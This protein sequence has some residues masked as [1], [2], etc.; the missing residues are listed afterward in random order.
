MKGSIRWWIFGIII[1]ILV[2]VIALYFAQGWPNL[3]ELFMNQ[4][5]VILMKYSTCS[6]AYCANGADSD[7]VKKVGCLKKEAGKC[8]LTCEDVEEKIFSKIVEK[9]P[10]FTFTSNSNKHYCGKDFALEFEFT[11]AWGGTVPL[12]SGQMDSF[13]A[14]QPQWV[15]KPVKIPFTDIEID[16]YQRYAPIPAFLKLT[17]ADMQYTGSF[18]GIEIPKNCIM[19]SKSVPDSAT[20]ANTI[21]FVVTF[22]PG[23]GQA[24]SA[25]SVIKNIKTDISKI[26]ELK[27]EISIL[28][29]ELSERSLAGAAST[30]I[31]GDAELNDPHLSNG[32]LTKGGCFT[33][34]V[35]DLT[36]DK[37]ASRI[38]VLYS[39]ILQYYNTEKGRKVKV[40]PSAIYVDESFIKSSECRLEN[41]EA[42]AFKNMDDTEKNK[43]INKKKEEYK[44][45]HKND[46]KYN[47]YDKDGNLI[48]LQ[49]VKVEKTEGGNDV[50][51]IGSVEN[52]GA[53][54]ALLEEDAEKHARSELGIGKPIFGVDV[55]G[56]SVLSW[57]S[58]F[59]IGNMVSECN[60]RAID[61]GKKIQYKVWSNPTYPGIGTVVNIEK[62]GESVTEPIKEFFGIQDDSSSGI[63]N[64]V[65]SDISKNLG[66]KSAGI[67]P[68]VLDYSKK[69]QNLK[70]VRDD[71][72][73]GSDSIS[74]AEEIVKRSK[75]ELI[76]YVYNSG[77]DDKAKDKIK[78][79]IESM[80]SSIESSTF[81]KDIKK[82]IED[83]LRE[84]GVEKDKEESTTTYDWH[85]NFGS[86]AYV[87]L[88]R[89][90][91]SVSGIIDQDQQKSST[92]Q[93]SIT[94]EGDKS[95]YNKNDIATFSGTLR[96]GPLLLANEEVKLVLYFLPGI[97]SPIPL[98]TQSVLTDGSGKFTW[99]TQLGGDFNANYQIIAEYNGVKSEPFKFTV[100]K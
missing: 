82:Y 17:T 27:N 77:I 43:R 58:Y 1:A 85:E 37:E 98:S 22:I 35:Y 90:L 74:V 13:L 9:N 100:G 80:E 5:Q 56:I 84:F 2:I 66:I 60:F 21:S 96:D 31:L 68:L 12:K 95:S 8:V 24:K 14:K 42:A 36:D 52:V 19:L 76:G 40:Y 64:A 7:Q 29:R 99:Q 33:G 3:E 88:S 70:E 57:K 6:L 32:M 49:R 48:T 69:L 11:G 38:N 62:F 23:A 28:N 81:D 26:K 59:D 91:S 78:G 86:C 67:E 63:S 20:Y 18:L 92:N 30:F 54:D 61:K 25:I 93:I 4:D 50:E 45:Q 83:I 65:R 46:I 10:S 72:N 55:F 41:E 87:T 75:E 73:A 53:G 79:I 39:P 97:G 51:Y 34:L 89:D 44:N 47:N 94:I 16:E 15:C 71:E